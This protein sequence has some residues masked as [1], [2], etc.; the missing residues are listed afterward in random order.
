MSREDPMTIEAPL[1]EVRDLV[2]EFPSD[3]TSS[4][5]LRAVDRVTFSI[6]PGE[7]LGLVGA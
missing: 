1:L 5:A 7:I 3:G 2:V 6:R 4:G